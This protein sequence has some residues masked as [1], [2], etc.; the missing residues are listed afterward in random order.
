MAYLLLWL[1]WRFF[2]FVFSIQL[3]VDAR[4]LLCL[5]V[6]SK[7]KCLINSLCLHYFQNVWTWKGRLVKGERISLWNS[8]LLK[9][10]KKTK[11]EQSVKGKCFLLRWSNLSHPLVNKIKVHRSSPNCSVWV[12]LQW[13]G[14]TL[15]DVKTVKVKYHCFKE[16]LELQTIKMIDV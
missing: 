13:G 2:V 8:P 14:V 6:H 4:N 1:F 7:L 11:M 3:F 16:N 12:I 9:L 5:M 15:M 10:L